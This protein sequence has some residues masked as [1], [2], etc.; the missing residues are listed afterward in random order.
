MVCNA[1][2]RRNQ[3]HNAESVRFVEPFHGGNLFEDYL[4]FLLL[5]QNLKGATNMYIGLLN[6]SKEPVGYTRQEDKRR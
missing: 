6:N 2:P 5:V 1:D 4:L 3:W